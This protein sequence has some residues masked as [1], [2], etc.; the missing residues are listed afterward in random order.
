MQQP[1]MIRIPKV[2]S[3]H[4]H[5]VKIVTSKC[6]ILKNHIQIHCKSQIIEGVKIKSGFEF[7]VPE[8]AYFLP[9]QPNSESIVKIKGYSLNPILKMLFINQLR[10]KS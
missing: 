10:N 3:L 2:D 5:P 9:A 4:Y 7:N 8:H 6:R 1:T